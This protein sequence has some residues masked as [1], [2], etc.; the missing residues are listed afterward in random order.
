MVHSAELAFWR[1]AEA[2]GLPGGAGEPARVAFGALR[3]AGLLD[4]TP[5]GT[6]VT[7]GVEAIE[8]PGHTPGHLAVVVGN[9]LLWAGDAF[10]ATSNVAHPDWVSAADM[11]PDANEA[12]RR[13][14]L[15]RA[16]NERWVLAASHLPETGRVD[17]RGD[18]FA[19]TPI[20]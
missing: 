19:F 6:S 8:A 3:A 7:S 4:E 14:L 15:A 18:G 10:V 1:S 16:A 12:T 2:R 17:R 5:E 9:A 20:H 13:T 11:D